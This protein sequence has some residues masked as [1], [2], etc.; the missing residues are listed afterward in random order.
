MAHVSTQYIVYNH[1]GTGVRH[2]HFSSANDIISATDDNYPGS[3]D[4][5]P[6]THTC[7]GFALSPDT[8]Q[9]PFAFMAVA[10]NV[11]TQH[12]FTSPGNPVIEVGSNNVT[13]LVVYG[14]VGG[15]GT[16]GDPG[17]WVDAFNLDTGA[18]SDDLHFISVLTPPTPPDNIDNAKTSWANQDGSISTVTAEHIRASQTIDGSA[19]FVEW[20]QIMSPASINNSRDVDL[21]QGDTNKIWFAFYQTPPPLQVPKINEEGSVWMYLSPGVLVGAGGWGIGPDGKPHP[22]GPNGPLIQKLMTTVGILS[23]ATNMSSR[24][25]EQAFK[26]AA[27][28]LDSIK[29]SILK[30]EGFEEKG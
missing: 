5:S 15:T 21:G 20:K 22:I 6:G 23:L 8:N 27:N 18:F 17:V 26:L 29:D 28:H 10:G 7:Y 16:N 11:G 2:H 14:P 13:V 12:L 9:Y 1:G 4:N 30:M 25:K 19:Q 24:E 3:S